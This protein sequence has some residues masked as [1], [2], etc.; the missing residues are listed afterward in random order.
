MAT[1]IVRQRED[2]LDMAEEA[3]YTTTHPRSTTQE[4]QQ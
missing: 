4:V 1:F 3:P 2:S